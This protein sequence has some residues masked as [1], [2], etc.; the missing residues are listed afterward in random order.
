MV[1]L[2]SYVNPQPS[3][4]DISSN[5]DVNYNGSLKL[6]F[7]DGKGVLN[8]GY[9][10]IDNFTLYYM[11][12]VSEVE[13]DIDHYSVSSV[14]VTAGGIYEITFNFNAALL[15]AGN[16]RIKYSYFAASTVYTVNF[17]KAAS[18]QAI[19][20]DLDYYSYDDDFSPSG[21]SFTTYISMGK[22]PSIDG[23]TSNFTTQTIEPFESFVQRIFIEYLL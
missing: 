6:I 4:I 18:N 14:A 16:Y 13:V 17:D 21:T 12:G 10:F 2:S 15:K 11:D 7:N 9:D 23:T 1:T 5:G 22:V 19:I 3:S 20:E 8:E